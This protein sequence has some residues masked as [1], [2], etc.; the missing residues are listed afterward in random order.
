MHRFKITYRD[1]AGGTKEV[2][3]VAANKEKA[4]K[5]FK[6]KVGGASDDDVLSMEPA[7]AKGSMAS[8]S[9][10]TSAHG[11]ASIAMGVIGVIAL[12]C[13]ALVLLN[14]TLNDG[15][16]VVNLQLL[17]IGEVLCIVGGVFCAVQWRP[18]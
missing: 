10:L 7:P 13:G 5:A 14:P 3:V 2:T 9:G 4:L 8:D 16:D 6:I 1:D 17:A 11:G 15:V 18:R 12:V